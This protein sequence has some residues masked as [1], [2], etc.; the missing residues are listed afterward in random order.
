VTNL[1][2]LDAFSRVAPCEP[3]SVTPVIENR[4]LKCPR[5]GDGYLHHCAVQVQDRD[6]EDG[7]GTQVYVGNGAV[8]VTRTEGH[9]YGTRRSAVRIGFYCELCD[10][11]EMTPRVVLVIRQHKGATLVDWEESQW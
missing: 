3:V 1:K 7:P 10:E 9:H 6:R 5:C 11:G 8:K 4:V 2:G